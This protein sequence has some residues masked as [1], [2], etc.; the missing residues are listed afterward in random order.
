MLQPS[1]YNLMETMP[2]STTSVALENNDEYRFAKVEPSNKRRRVTLDAMDTNM[3]MTMTMPT[4]PQL[5]QEPSRK[6]VKKTVRFAD[7]V[8]VAFRHVSKE[9]LQQ[10]WYSDEE[11][12]AF[13]EDIRDTI[14]VYRGM[15][16]GYN[17]SL[18]CMMDPNW[19]CV[20]GVE[21]HVMQGSFQIKK[22]KLLSNIRMIL[23]QQ[24]MQRNMGIYDPNA[25]RM[26]SMMCSR[27]SRLRALDR[28]ALDSTDRF[29]YY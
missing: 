18:L 26:I 20:R 23:D 16:L 3:K 6:R 22:L 2:L 8:E 5:Q 12:R 11:F 27:Q 10:C 4:K 28:A 9:E 7:A 21:E 25:L 29:N 15:G 13:V 19:Y 17:N 14:R 24:A 1:P